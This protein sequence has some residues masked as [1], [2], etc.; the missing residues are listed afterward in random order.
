MKWMLKN[1]IIVFCLL[2]VV[3]L[4]AGCEDGGS[5]GGGSGDIGANNPN[6]IVCLGDSITEGMPGG[7]APFPAR[8]VGLTGKQVVNQGEGGE[9][10]RGGAARAPAVLKRYKPAA[11][12]ILFGANDLIQGESIEGAIAGLRSIIASCR[13]NQTEPILATLTPMT[14]G[15]E[16]W[17]G[18]VVMLN[19]QIRA[20]ASVENVRLVDLEREFGSDPGMLLVPDGLHPNDL[21]NQVIAVAFADAL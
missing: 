17:A 6:V 4:L 11:M 21:G 1:V 2:S 18:G 10:A 13:A 19:E 9:K 5:G 20:L 3:T 12:T 16:L 14:A 8:M 7:G 15:H